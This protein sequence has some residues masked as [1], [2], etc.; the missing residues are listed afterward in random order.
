MRGEIQVK[1]VIQARLCIL[2]TINA[3][4]EVAFRTFHEE[5]MQ[6]TGYC[7]LPSML[8]FY[9]EDA[10]DV[11]CRGTNEVHGWHIR[12][13]LSARIYGEMQRYS[14]LLPQVLYSQHIIS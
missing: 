4:Q 2:H 5:S 10:L 8:A 14:T 13:G 7:C 1:R 12:Y 9:L 3:S 11:F 6:M